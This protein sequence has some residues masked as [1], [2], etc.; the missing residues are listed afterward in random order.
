MI[1]IAELF[2]LIAL[3]HLLFMAA[4]LWTGRK[5]LAKPVG[6]PI[7][8]ALCVGGYLVIDAPFWNDLPVLNLLFHTLPFLA[9]MAFW[10]FCKWI[11]DDKFRW[12]GW[13]WGLMAGMLALY[14]FV[15]ILE[16]Y[17][18]LAPSNDV[19]IFAGV[20]T[21][22]TS[23]I[24]IFLGIGEALRNREADLV[25]SR[26]QFRKIFVISVALLMAMTA[27][28]EIS[29]AGNAPPA[30]LQLL[31]R[32]AIVA[33]VWFFAYFS[34]SLREQF[35]PERQSP[36]A[37]SKNLENTSEP[38]SQLLEKLD[39]AMKKSEIWRTEGLT[40]RQLAEHLDVKEYRL[41][42]AINRHLGYRNFN[43]YLHGFRIKKAC[44]LLAD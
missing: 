13:W 26:I 9:P 32:I 41:R 14:Y 1:S 37:F 27:L 33:L 22:L 7:F 15:W 10:L 4:L 42:Q 3:S 18:W 30:S 31:Q 39:A 40:I 12:K 16:K 20:L 36:A 5:N 43:D 29:L 19:W 8:F 44:D 21:Q 38:D 35:F 2:A 23:L 6:V 34:L 17:R 25:W 24:F 28:V 11:F